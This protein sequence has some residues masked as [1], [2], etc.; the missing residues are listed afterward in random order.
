MKIKTI[1]CHDV[2]NFGAS[3]QAYALM[4]YLKSQGNDVKVI[5]YMP[6]YIRDFN[7]IWFISEKY[8]RNI[9]IAFAYYCYVIPIRLTQ[10]AKRKKFRS[11]INDNLNLTKRYN[12]FE[13]LK[14]SPPDADI[15]F[16]GSDQIW[17]TEINN[18]LDPAFYA[19]F[20]KPVTIRASYAASFSISSIPNKHEPFVMEMLSKM[21]CISVREK[22]GLDILNTLG[23]QGGINVIDPVFLLNKTQWDELTYPICK[24]GYV[25][26]Y[27]QEDSEEIKKTAC[28]IA[29][30][31]NLRIIAF[32][33]LYTRNYASEQIRNAGPREFL[34]YIK[35]AK[36]VITNSFHCTAFSLIFER[37]FFVVA[38]TRQMVNS[39]MKDLLNLLLLQ[40]RY[41]K[42][43]TDISYSNINYKEV[44]KKLH[45]RISQSKDYIAGVITL[46]SNRK[47]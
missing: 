38:R 23:I 6:K 35:G 8:S 26:V 27:D 47:A 2:Y 11:F 32:R 44:S 37:D 15:I 33:D 41:I 12:S 28:N 30:E 1:T 10:R 3:L 22:T 39:R 36:Y 20:A 21:D 14:A 17:N 5:D 29:S 31:K 46:A 40:E 25:L 34:S 7:S 19:G 18:G 42:D 43:E 13:E 4:T 24:D 9:F 45:D 16:C